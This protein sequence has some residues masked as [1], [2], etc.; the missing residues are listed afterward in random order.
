MGVF[1]QIATSK[2][3]HANLRANLLTRLCEWGQEVAAA[4]LCRR[5]EIQANVPIWIIQIPTES[6][7]S[8]T[9]FSSI[10]ALLICLFNLI[11]RK[12]EINLLVFLFGIDRDHL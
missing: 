4:I 6:E 10:S 5:L 2:G 7:V 1:T 11:L 12:L 3:L 9:N 8:N